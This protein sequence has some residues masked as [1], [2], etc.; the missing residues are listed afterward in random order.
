M[1]SSRRLSLSAIQPRLVQ[2]LG[3]QARHQLEL[4]DARAVGAAAL[5]LAIADSHQAVIDSILNRMRIRLVLD[6]EP[7]RA[8]LTDGHSMRPPGFAGLREEPRTG[9]WDPSIP[10][11][12]DDISEIAESCLEAQAERGASDVLT[13]AYVYP[14]PLGAA[15][16]NDLELARATCDIASDRLLRLGQPDGSPRKVLATINV[17]PAALDDSSSAELID[18]YADIDVDGYWLCAVN[19]SAARPQ[20]DSIIALALGLEERT[21]KSVTVVG[22]GRMWQAA[23]A[24]GASA[25]CFGPGLARFAFPS[26]DL[27]EEF[28]E[29]EGVGVAV[30]HPRA[31][32]AVRVGWPGDVSRRRLFVRYPCDCGEHPANEAPQGKGATMRHNA[33]CLAMEAA[34]ASG[35]VKTAS[36]QARVATARQL[37]AAVEM[38]PLASGWLAAAERSAGAQRRAGGE[39]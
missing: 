32:G 19:F 38:G 10:L 24:N 1:E 4:M 5:P 15:R 14:E 12:H 34:A 9:S 22:L 21:G 18:A 17:Y 23:V 33:R 31:L 13:R 26:E 29:V 7:W 35:L 16:H 28:D 37:R 30:Y 3:A 25:S 39:S 2:W 8:Q 27:R 11:S 20:Y 6:P 36:L